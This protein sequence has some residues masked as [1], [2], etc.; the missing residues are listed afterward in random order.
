MVLDRASGYRLIVNEFLNDVIHNGLRLPPINDALLLETVLDFQNLSI[1]VVFVV[2]LRGVLLVEFARVIRVLQRLL[3]HVYLL[4]LHI[5]LEL[6]QLTLHLLQHAA[7]PEKYLLDQTSPAWI[8]HVLSMHQNGSNHR[9]S[10]NRRSNLFYL[11]VQYELLGQQIVDKKN[12]ECQIYL[13]L[14]FLEESVVPSP[15]AR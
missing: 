1:V 10:E 3:D 2:G 13:Y 15:R 6:A 7:L 12:K 5:Q 9:D 11:D 8:V 14:Y 4:Q